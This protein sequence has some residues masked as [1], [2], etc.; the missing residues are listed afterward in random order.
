M[1]TYELIVILRNKDLD[2]MKG[3]VR[4]IL[5][6]QG[7]KVILDEP[8]G[9]KR[10]AYEIDREREGYYEFMHVELSPANV[11]EIINEFRIQVDV[12]RYLFVKLKETK[13]A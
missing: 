13:V 1:N 3:K 8:W 9:N 5:E 6:K 7:A 11:Q 10:L 2:T 4:S 12:L